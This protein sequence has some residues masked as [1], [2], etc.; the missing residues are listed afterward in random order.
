MIRVILEIKNISSE[1]IFSELDCINSSFEFGRIRR[2]TYKLFDNS[3][4]ES[5]MGSEY[6]SAGMQCTWLMVRCRCEC[7][8]AKKLKF[9]SPFAKIAG[10]GYEIREKLG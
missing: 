9:L 5:H 1:S 4:S 2:G 6:G 10:A 8:R 3:M 7:C